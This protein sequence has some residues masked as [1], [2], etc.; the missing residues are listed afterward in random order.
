M[1]DRTLCLEARVLVRVALAL[2]LLAAVATVWEVLAMQWPDSPFH[3]GVLAGPI[4]QLRG[5]SFALGG[6]LALAAWLWPSLYGAG[7]GRYALGLLLGGALIHSL[8]LLYGAA[9]G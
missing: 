6:G 9:H 7:K 2:W 3:L 8:A 4:G 1:S 5:F